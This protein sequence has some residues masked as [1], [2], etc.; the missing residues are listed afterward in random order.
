MN[1]ESSPAYFLALDMLRMAFS[2]T[3][4]VL[5]DRNI[6]GFQGVAGDCVSLGWPHAA[7]HLVTVSTW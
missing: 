6:S 2:I 7:V 3:A 1:E 5:L 4:K